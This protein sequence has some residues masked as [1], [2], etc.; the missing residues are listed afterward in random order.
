MDCSFVGK[1]LFDVVVSIVAVV[2]VV[3]VVVFFFLAKCLVSGGCNIFYLFR[4]KSIKID[5]TTP[6]IIQI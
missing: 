4:I 1:N 3:A 5:V 2:V 6:K